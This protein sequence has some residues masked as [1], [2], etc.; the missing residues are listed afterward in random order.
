MFTYILIYK[1]HE[2]N[3]GLNVNYKIVINHSLL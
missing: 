3:Y 1:Q 2:N